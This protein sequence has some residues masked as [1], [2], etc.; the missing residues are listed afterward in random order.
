MPIGN[1]QWSSLGIKSSFFARWGE[2]SLIA[3]GCNFKDFFCIQTWT[4]EVKLHKLFHIIFALLKHMFE[5]IPMTSSHLREAMKISRSH[6]V[7]PSTK[8][9]TGRANPI[10]CAVGLR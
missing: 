9:I 7:F 8:D 4:N 3:E 2:T 5:L 1:L 6:K 10:S